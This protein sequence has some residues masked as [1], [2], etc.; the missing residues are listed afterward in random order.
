MTDFLLHGAQWSQKSLLL[1]NKEA[2][3]ALPTFPLCLKIR[4][5]HRHTLIQMKVRNVQITV[6]IV[7][8]INWSNR[9]NIHNLWT[10]T[11]NSEVVPFLVHALKK[12]KWLSGHCTSAWQS[13]DSLAL[14]CGVLLWF[15][16]N[17]LN[18][19]VL[20]VLIS[21]SFYLCVYVYFNYL[22]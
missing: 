8:P 4:L 15:C 16:D 3:M 9:V 14:S 5:K 22:I 18:Y 12:I 10:G 6:L 1:F 17:K 2:F 13:S 7:D 20:C 11:R 21:F 19:V